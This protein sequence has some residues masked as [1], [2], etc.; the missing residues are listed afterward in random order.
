MKKLIFLST[1]MIFTV[2][3]AE[4]VD[5]DSPQNNQTSSKITPPTWIQGTWIFED[6]ASNGYKF[7]KD[8][9]CQLIS[10]GAET[11]M[12]EIINIYEGTQIQTNVDQRISDTEYYCKVTYSG[13]STI[14]HFQKVSDN[15]IKD[16]NMSSSSGRTILL[17]KQ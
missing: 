7:K 2:S 8:D 14:M 17:I 15:K 9:V 6:V 13:A 11:C 12:K 1:A 4:T 16:I 5:S 10:T 3:C